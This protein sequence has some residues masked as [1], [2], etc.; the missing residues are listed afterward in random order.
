MQCNSQC[1]RQQHNIV[2]ES[3]I[4]VILMLSVFLV[5]RV[6]PYIA[7][8]VEEHIP[9]F[10]L[11][12]S[13]LASNLDDVFLLLLT[14]CEISFYS[15]NSVPV[16]GVSFNQLWNGKC[17]YL[18]IWVKCGTDAFHSTRRMV[19][20]HLYIDISDFLYFYRT[21]VYLGS[22]LWVRSLTEWVRDVVETIHV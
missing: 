14:F 5:L 9:M 7:F 11:S 13:F 17:V 22:D 1:V 8:L 3:K 2:W 19:M 15:A 4:A 21:Q 18:Q 6:F 16:L 12:V 20:V 10:C